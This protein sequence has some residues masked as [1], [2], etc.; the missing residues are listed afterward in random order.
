MK[1]FLLA[2]LAAG[3]WMNLNEFARNE[4]VVKQIWIDGFAKTGLPY[5]STPVTGIAW[6]LWAFIFIA[7]LTWLVTKFS[8]LQS[9]LIT[10]IVGFVLLWL[11]LWNLGVLPE[12]LLYVAAPWSFVEVYVSALICRKILGEPAM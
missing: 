5:Q 12:G 11:G 8:V 1:K 9:T 7:I 6:M 3:V 10:W 4:L 2:I